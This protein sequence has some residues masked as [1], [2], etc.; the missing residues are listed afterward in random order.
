MG[1]KTKVWLNMYVLSRCSPPHAILASLHPSSYRNKE[2]DIVVTVTLLYLYCALL[3]PHYAGNNKPGVFRRL[4]TSKSRKT[5]TR[6]G[7]HLYWRSVLVIYLSYLDIFVT[8]T[9]VYHLLNVIISDTLFALNCFLFYAIM[10]YY[11]ISFIV[12][13]MCCFSSEIFPYYTYYR[14]IVCG[15]CKIDNAQKIMRGI[16]WFRELDFLAGLRYDVMAALETEL[17][18]PCQL[19][20]LLNEEDDSRLLTRRCKGKT[21]SH[22]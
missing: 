8:L 5:R 16:I 6:A 9:R 12:S 3:S 11:M 2:K 7:R 18:G 4:K 17:F 1:H 19:V 20:F 22:S 14:V 10:S 15:A 13:A 21:A